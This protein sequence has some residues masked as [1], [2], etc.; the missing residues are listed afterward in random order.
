MRWLAVAGSITCAWNLCAPSAAQGPLL[1]AGREWTI[2][3]HEMGCAISA[4]IGGNIVKRATIPGHLKN[5][6]VG[7]LSLDVADKAAAGNTTVAIKVG[8]LPPRMADANRGPAGDGDGIWL[9][10]NAAELTAI[11]AGEPV[12]VELSGETLLIHTAQAA[13]QIGPLSACAGEQ[14]AAFRR[15]GK[16]APVIILP[17]DAPASAAATGEKPALNSI[18]I[19]KDDGTSA[20]LLNIGEVFRSEDYPLEAIAKKEQ[21]TTV[22]SLSI[23]RSGRATDCRISQSSGSSS[24][25]KT[26]CALLMERGRFEI[27]RDASGKPVARVGSTRISW[28]LP[29]GGQMVKW[30]DSVHR[31]IFGIASGNKAGEC[32]TEPSDGF[33]APMDLCDRLRPKADR[34]LASVPVNIDYAGRELV[35]EAGSLVGEGADSLP[36]GKEVGS[37]LIDRS[38]VAVTRDDKGMATGCVAGRNDPISKDDLEKI[39]AQIANAKPDSSVSD[40]AERIQPHKWVFYNAVYLRPHPAGPSE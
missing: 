32:R 37:I 27:G 25:D 20:N 4:R 30:V 28:S 3:R 11:T 29:D 16:P 23:D 1:E 17:Q 26:S 40:E 39:C 9:F 18:G 5:G 8:Q 34:Y 21:G 7:G 22:A 24:L 35:Y 14:L 6:Q 36:V 2:E 10:F 33:G 12:R 13:A 19:G 38:V 31:A 15:S